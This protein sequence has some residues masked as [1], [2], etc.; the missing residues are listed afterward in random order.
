MSRKLHV[1]CCRNYRLEFEA[2]VAAEGWS[3][4]ALAQFPARCG[5][6]PVAWSELATLADGAE[7]DLLV[8][9]GPC[10]S[11]LEIPP[12]R[13]D[14]VRLHRRAQCFELIA[15]PAQIADALSRNAY[16][17]T[18]GWLGAWRE[19]LEEL[20]FTGTS[21]AALFREFA[22]ELVLL[23]T[24]VASDAAARLTELARTLALPCSRTPVGIE[25]TRGLLARHVGEWRLDVER[26]AAAARDA[27]HARDRADLVAT[28]EFVSRLVVLGSESETIAAIEELCRMLFAPRTLH[29]V[30]VE[31]D[32]IDGAVPGHVRSQIAGLHDDWAW[33]ASGTG[34]MLR[35]A[36][37]GETV[38]VILVDGLAFPEYRERYLDLARSVARVSG[39]AIQNTRSYRRLETA[40]ES[41]RRSERNLRLAQALAHVGH[42]EYD[43]NA[44][45]F[46]WSD[47]TYR[48]LG[49]VPGALTPSREAFLAA[50]H[51]EDRAAVAEELR[52][53][54]TTGRFEL[55]YRI[56][57]PDGAVRFV[58]AVGEV[59][60]A[61]AER[62][63][64]VPGTGQDL[65]GAR[66]AQLLGVLQDVSERKALQRRLDDGSGADPVTGCATRPAFLR[67]A[68]RELSR[69]RRYG[70]ELSL[71]ALRLD[72]HR[73]HPAADAALGELARV[74]VAALRVHDVVGRLGAEELVILLPETG[75]GEAAEA[76]E[77]LRQAVAQVELRS[78]D[79]SPLRFTTSVGIAAG[80]GA[81]PGV[82]T[83]LERAQG[84]LGEAR[85][86]GRDRVVT[87]AP[88]AAGAAPRRRETTPP[89]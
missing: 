52:R 56:L 23:D 72:D 59:V 40:E 19:H 61:G 63:P 58:H 77:R 36:H 25:P 83:V 20:G 29:V 22:R 7:A 18:P 1:L 41:L 3:D 32:T 11:A 70:G 47:E 45:A 43:G 88:S 66:P 17:V 46:H 16:L 82:Q 26:R 44:D 39:L 53:S 27:S 2:A 28:L 33:T 74:C 4:V 10:L 14:H 86:T 12:E 79:G 60:F 48:I 68:E 42:W 84:A 64:R 8:L 57:L 15:C 76:A 73:G 80:S 13:R 71:M 35:V 5:R 69:V 87:H 78:P 81:E 38:A 34:F 89:G 65:V 75:P 67:E 21:A 49:Y 30:R 51:P 62:L 24:G 9:G 55:E 50:A 37:A 54:R 6:P 85:A 31:D